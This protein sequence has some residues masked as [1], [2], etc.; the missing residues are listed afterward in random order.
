MPSVARIR[1]AELYFSGASEVSLDREPKES[2]DAAEALEL[3]SRLV[4]SAH[5]DDG[6]AGGLDRPH[7]LL[8]PG[9]ADDRVA[10][11]EGL[12]RPGIRRLLHLRRSV[13]VGTVRRERLQQFLDERRLVSDA[14]LAEHLRTD[15]GL[16]R[17]LNP[18]H[19]G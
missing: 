1:V 9:I 11:Q 19:T 10:H 6:P 7:D 17:F 3:L 18:L 2:G 4:V 13:G 15:A 14:A 16:Q 12:D 8:D 5:E